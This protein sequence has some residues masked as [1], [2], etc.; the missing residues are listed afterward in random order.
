[1]IWYRPAKVDPVVSS[2]LGASI[3]SV[4]PL[5][6]GSPKG[7]AHSPQNFWVSGFSVWHFGHLMAIYSPY[8]GRKK[9]YQGTE[10]VS[11]VKK[12]NTQNILFP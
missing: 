5:S 12:V 2:S 7:V 1:M 9:E 8:I 4:A 10:K 11:N 3:V 6:P